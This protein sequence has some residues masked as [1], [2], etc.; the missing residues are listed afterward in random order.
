MGRGRSIGC[1]AI[2]LALF[3]AT[4]LADA[5]DRKPTAQRERAAVY[6]LLTSREVRAVTPRP[7]VSEQE[8]A[9][10]N[11][12]YFKVGAFT[13]QPAVGGVNGAQFSIGF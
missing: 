10:P 12:L 11:P 3:V 13:L 7:K 2:L 5:R 8:A 4:G 6:A 9:P 1:A